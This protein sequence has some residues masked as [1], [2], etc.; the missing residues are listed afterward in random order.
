VYLRSWWFALL[1]VALFCL[2]HEKIMFAE[3]EYLR[4]KFGEAFLKWAEQ[5]PA[6]IPD[7]KKWR[8]PGPPFSFRV[9]VKTEYSTFFSIIASFTFVEIVEDFFVQGRL[10]FEVMWAVIFG[11]GLA[12]YLTLRILDKRTKLLDA[13]SR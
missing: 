10:V 5:T 11:S 3:E 8:S 2:Y 12:M 7:F 9:A 13:E 4:K 1:F 6:F